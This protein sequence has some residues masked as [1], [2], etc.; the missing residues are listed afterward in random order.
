M[1][2]CLRGIREE[3]LWVENW[4]TRMSQTYTKQEDNTRQKNE[5]E[6]DRFEICLGLCNWLDVKDEGKRCQGW[7]SSFWHK[8]YN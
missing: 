7:L 3:F 6:D 4:N 1:N 5:V 2:I 8:Y